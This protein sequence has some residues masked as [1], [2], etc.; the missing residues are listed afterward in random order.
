MKKRAPDGKLTITI[1]LNE[2]KDCVDEYHCFFNQR[3]S[4]FEL[5]KFLAN[6]QTLCVLKR[7][8]A[9]TTYKW[10]IQNVVVTRV[11]RCR[12]LPAQ[13]NL[14]NNKQCLEVLICFK[15]NLDLYTSSLIVRI[16]LVLHQ[17]KRRNSEVQVFPTE[18]SS[19]V[20]TLFHKVVSFKRYHETGTL[21]SIKRITQVNFFQQ[22]HGKVKEIPPKNPFH[23]GNTTSLR[24][25][26]F[27]PFFTNSASCRKQ[28]SPCLC[29]N[30]NPLL[31]CIFSTSLPSSG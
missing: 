27:T 19:F 5:K 30:A 7:K 23:I 21:V 9:S 11:Q 10:A 26:H 14:S 28:A 20:S 1:Q 16:L 24:K 2:Y 25:T 15:S 6:S 12:P 4:T 8:L 17:V 22:H 13:K 3:Y 31:E 29:N 18:L